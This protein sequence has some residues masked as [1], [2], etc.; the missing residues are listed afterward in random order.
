M[1]KNTLHQLR[2]ALLFPV[3]LLYYEILLRVTT[4]GGL[5]QVGT[6][7]MVVLCG[8]YGLV[9]WLLTSL[10]PSRK[11]RHISSVCLVALTA[12][13]YGV[14]HFI[15][16]QFGLFYDLNTITGGAADALTGFTGELIKLLFNF[17]GI[18]MIILFL[19]PAILLA[20]LG[21]RPQVYA[22]L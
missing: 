10:F 2:A 20:V 19:L 6:V 21:R 16:R 5:I 22:I 7:F 3:V 15:F 1:K 11:G 14:E 4:V 12:L 13:P 9:C 17:N 18:S 8:A